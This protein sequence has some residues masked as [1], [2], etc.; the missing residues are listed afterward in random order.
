MVKLSNP[1]PTYGPECY[2]VYKNNIPFPV[3][4]LKSIDTKNGML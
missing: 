2:P 3:S 4:I 1:K